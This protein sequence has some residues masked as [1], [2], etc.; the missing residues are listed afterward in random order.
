LYGQEYG[1]IAIEVDAP[2]N[3][4][5]PGKVSVEFALNPSGSTILR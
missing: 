4:Q 3:D 2:Y 1:R 5:V